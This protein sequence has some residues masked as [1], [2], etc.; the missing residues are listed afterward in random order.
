VVRGKVEGFAAQ[1]IDD[2]AAKNKAMDRARNYFGL[3]DYYVR[4]FQKPF[5]PVVFMGLSG[6]GKSTIARDFS[7]NSIILRSD[8]IR[9]EITGIRPG[10][11]AYSAFR[12]GIYTQE[13]TRQVYCTLLE[14]AINHAKK[15][16]KVIVDATYLKASQ[17][18]DFF[19][20][21]MENGLNPFFI[22]CFAAEDVLKTRIRERIR[23]GTDVSDAD[24][25]VLENQLQHLEEP[26]ELPCYRVLRINTEDVLH[27]I[28][29]ALREFL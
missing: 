13:L 24:L 6:S 27:R 28:I 19:Q 4:H 11:H 7:P 2:Q 3:A 8:E 25:A 16:R 9:K 5:N 1:A 12:K 21:C 15:G 14:K 22:H 20:T 10:T 26:E 23:E 18:K 17:R 29:Y